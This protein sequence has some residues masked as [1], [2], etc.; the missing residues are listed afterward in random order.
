MKYFVFLFFDNSLYGS[1][2]HGSFVVL[3]DF[4]ERVR[5]TISIVRVVLDDLE[6]LRLVFTE[7]I[8]S[9]NLEKI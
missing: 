8:S 5:K 1:K 6:A 4:G 3:A 7:N 2:I 9:R